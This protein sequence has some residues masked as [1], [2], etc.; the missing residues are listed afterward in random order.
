MAAGELELLLD[1]VEAVLTFAAAVVLVVVLAD[2]L[3][4][5]V[6]LPTDKVL[7]LNG[8]LMTLKLLA[9]GMVV[10]YQLPFARAQLWPSG[11][12]P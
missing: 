10:K 12:V 4:V 5:A 7:T 2:F 11:A 6:A 9:V 3:A 1:E 8:W